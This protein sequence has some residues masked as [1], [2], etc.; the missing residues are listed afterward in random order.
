[1]IRLRAR[2]IV[3]TVLWL[4]MTVDVHAQTLF[5]SQGIELRGS[6]RIIEYEPETCEVLEAYE[7]PASYR[8][9]MVTQGQPIDVW[10]L[11]YSVHNGSGRPL[12]QLNASF[13]IEAPEPPCTN[14]SL[15]ANRASRRVH[16]RATVGEIRRGS[17]DPTAPGE[18]P[19]ATS[20]IY[21]FRG[22]EP[23]FAS[24]NVNYRFAAAPDVS[25]A[26][27]DV[28]PADVFSD[29][30]ECP[31]MVVVP[32][33]AFTMGSPP[34]RH[35]VTIGAPLAVGV[36]EVTFAEWDACVNAGGCGGHWPSDQGWGR[37]D[38]PVIGVSWDDAQAYVSWLS[39]HTGQDYRLL[40]EEEWEYS[41][42]AGTVTERF[43]G[44]TESDQCRYANGY[45][46]TAHAERGVSEP[47]TCSDGYASTAPV[48]SFV[49]NR[50][51]LYDML[52]NVYE[53]TQDCWNGSY[54]GAPTDGSA[55]QSGD[56]GDR[57]LRSG[58][59]TGS[60]WR[61][62]STSRDWNPTDS[63]FNNIGIRV[64]RTLR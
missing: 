18:T 63:R 34:S 27:V 8:R 28:A 60:P 10:Q 5:E 30:A 9:K 50:F 33:G 24:W 58:S 42:R 57:V 3:A 25:P 62:R 61:L 36:Y 1:M 22:H 45:D 11:D 53:W 48:G 19:A 49:P 2:W 52:G 54:A 46:A 47:V 64:A 41:A 29:C 32:A 31:Q 59:W 38:R 14:G 7:A 44:D 17:G 55:W 26:A 56:C 21:V 20:Y 23:G 6:A 39:R 15:P 51:G 40:S 13:R 16:L 43:W 37:G 4:G 35:H 12:D